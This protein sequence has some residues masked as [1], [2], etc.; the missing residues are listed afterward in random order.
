MNQVPYT[1]FSTHLT[2][3]RVKGTITDELIGWLEPVE[4][5]ILDEGDTLLIY[6]NLDQSGLYGVLLKMRDLGL[7]LISLQTGYAGR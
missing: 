7:N 6:A 5:R 2:S 4:Y 3:I 1:P